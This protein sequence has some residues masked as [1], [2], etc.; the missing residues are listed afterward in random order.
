MAATSAATADLTF[1]GDTT[2][3]W[4]SPDGTVEYGFCGACG[5]SMFWR[6]IARTTEVSICAGTLQTPTGLHTSTAWWLDEASDY[7]EVSPGVTDRRGRE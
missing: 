3:K 4:F 1:E 5:S 2:L 7:F 6:I